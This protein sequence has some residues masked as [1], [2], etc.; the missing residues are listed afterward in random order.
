M[1]NNS[2]GQ[3]QLGGGTPQFVD[4]SKFKTATQAAQE[5]MAQ[6]AAEQPKQ[7]NND[8]GNNTDQVA[9]ALGNQMLRDLGAA[10]INPVAAGFKLNDQIM[11]TM[12]SAPFNLI[13]N[14]ENK[15]NEEPAQEEPKEEPA[16]EEPKEEENAEYVEYTYKPGDTFGQV[17]LDLG[18]ETDA[19]LWGTDGDVNY[20]TQQLV[21]QG[22]LDERGNVPI[23]TTIRLKKRK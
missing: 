13:K 16:Q 19:G 22:A 21:E 9:A 10:I 5:R 7:E 8:N 20:Y 17:V 4:F 12:I 15:Q 23:G 6:R 18:L 1:N 11:R 3:F 2:F 14:G